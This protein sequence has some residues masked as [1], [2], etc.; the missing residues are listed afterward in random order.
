M[1]SIRDITLPPD[2]KAF[3]EFEAIGFLSYKPTTYQVRLTSGEVV[4]VCDNAKIFIAYPEVEQKTYNVQAWSHLAQALGKYGIAGSKVYMR[5][6][7]KKGKSGEYVLLSYLEFL[8]TKEET[9][10]RQKRNL[11]YRKT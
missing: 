5:G 10:R 7:L 3:T 8:E 1:L 4:D 9:L 2:K 6:K 11:E